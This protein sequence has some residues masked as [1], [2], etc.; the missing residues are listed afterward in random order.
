MTYAIAQRQ[1]ARIVEFYAIRHDRPEDEEVVIEGI[2]M[3]GN[4]REENK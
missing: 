2:E 4:V 3:L 1:C